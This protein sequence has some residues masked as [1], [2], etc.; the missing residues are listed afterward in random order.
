VTVQSVSW[1]DLVGW[2]TDLVSQR[3]AEVQSLRTVAVRV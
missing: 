3:I 1:T 2:M